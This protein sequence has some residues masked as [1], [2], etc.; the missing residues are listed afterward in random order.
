MHTAGKKQRTEKR[1]KME[2]ALDHA[3]HSFVK[4]Q[5]DAEERYMNVKNDGKTNG[6]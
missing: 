2:K 1:G 3:M 4:Y 6:D 5:Q